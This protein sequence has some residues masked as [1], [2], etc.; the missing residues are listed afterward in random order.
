MTSIW[1]AVRRVSACLI[2]GITMS[3]I[4]AA[5]AAA[6]VTSLTMISDSGD[7]I[8]AG[9]T[10][11]Y[12]P[13]DGTFQAY[14]PSSG[15]VA[16]NFYGS[17]H[18]W[19]LFFSHPY[20]TQLTPGVYTNAIRM[21]SAP[22]GTPGLDVFGDGRGCNMLSGSFTVLQAQYDTYG[23]L[24]AFDATFEQHCENFTP[25]L[26][27]EIRYNASVPLYVLA[28]S[29]VT[30]PPGQTTQFTVT[31]SDSQQ[32]VVRL[33]ASS[34]PAGASFQDNGNNTG[35]FTW[36]PTL[37]Q[38]GSYTVTFS[39]DN[40]AGLTSTSYTRINVVPPPPSNDEIG[41]AIP[42]TSLP[43]T[44]TQNVT[45]A[46]GSYQDP[47]CFGQ[48]QSVWY[49]YTPATAGRIEVNTNGST[50]DTAISVVTGTPGSYLTPIVC[51]GDTNGS[52]ASRAVFD[53]VPGTTY[54]IVVLSQFYPSSNA[55]L[56]LNVRPGPPAFTFNPTLQQFSSVVASTGQVTLY[57]NVTCNLPSMVYLS[58]NLRQ[59]NAG[60]P[61]NGY[62]GTAVFCNGSTPFTVP[63]S[64]YAV[65]KDKGRA[66]VFFGGG[67]ADAF[68]SANAYDPDTGQYKY[69]SFISTIQLRGK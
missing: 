13:A 4:C 49:S 25:A 28:P 26:R 16:V 35:T 37:A 68:V 39:G 33:S 18:N 55:N 63:V 3:T 29:T 27:G 34:L 42:I 50:Y 56:V 44:L 38:N 53:A 54:Y 11:N 45:Y 36:T 47:Y 40:Q 48:H 31:A 9:Q 5:P 57:G 51:N 69:I 8:G 61:I 64:S 66:S 14:V 23:T 6:Q 15:V 30:A 52:T 43:Q 41:G 46:T 19:N 60:V 2:A 32:R 12:T 1:N 22:S 7:Y 10:Y 24:T 17:G 62:W 67:K 65:M 59:V 20:R 58:G 21:T